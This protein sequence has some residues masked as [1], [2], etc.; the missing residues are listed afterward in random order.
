MPPSL[1]VDV[2]HI[3][4]GGT[5]LL[6]MVLEISFALRAAAKIDKV[7]AACRVAQADELSAKR[8]P[9]G[10]RT[11]IRLAMPIS[12]IEEIDGRAPRV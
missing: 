2:D 6:N 5:E 8:I 4:F 9:P 3:S 1:S 11:A 7:V 12:A 10:C